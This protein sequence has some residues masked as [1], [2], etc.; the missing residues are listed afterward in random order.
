MVEVTL[1]SSLSIAAARS[2]TSSSMSPSIQAYLVI[3]QHRPRADL[4]IR[5][6]QGWQAQ[7]FNSLDDVIVLAVLGCELPLEQ[8]Y[9]GI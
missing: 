9:R 2:A 1:L 7:L 3:N 5:A 4:C 8:V 6:S